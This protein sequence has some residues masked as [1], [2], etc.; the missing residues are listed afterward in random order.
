MKSIRG[1][2]SPIKKNIY[3]VELKDTIESFEMIETE[4]LEKIVMKVANK[5]GTEEGISS[6]LLKSIFHVIKDEFVGVI[7]DSLRTGQRPD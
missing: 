1:N 2:K 6:E 3:A 4:Y 5:K 7:N